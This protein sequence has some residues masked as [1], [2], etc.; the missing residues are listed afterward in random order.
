MGYRREIEGMM[1]MLLDSVIV[2]KNFCILL[3]PELNV[4]LLIQNTDF[5]LQYHD[6]SLHIS[7]VCAASEIHAR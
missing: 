4:I 1:T 7:P 2:K 5:S 3:M 6:L